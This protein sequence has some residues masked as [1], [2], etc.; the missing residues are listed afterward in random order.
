MNNQLLKR[1]TFVLDRDTADQLDAISARMGVS[2]SALVRDVLAEPVAMMARWVSSLPDQPTKG[3]ADA[4]I[5]RMGVDIDE[6]VE[7]RGGQLSLLR[8]PSAGNG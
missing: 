8:I 4:L 2:R 1:S 6:F 7:R 5:A 3:D